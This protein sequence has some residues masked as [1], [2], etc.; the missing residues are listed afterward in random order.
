MQA[1]PFI[2]R[3]LNEY[4][5]AEEHPSLAGGAAH[6]G[7]APLSLAAQRDYVALAHVKVGLETLAVIDADGAGGDL[8]RRLAAA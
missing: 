8:P 5:A 2:G 1:L 4:L 3:E 7:D 6:L